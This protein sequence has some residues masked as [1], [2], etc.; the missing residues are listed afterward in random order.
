MNN[1]I[2][3]CSSCGGKNRVPQAKQHLSAKCGKCGTGLDTQGHARPIELGDHDF[4]HFIK[5][6]DLPV[7]VDFFSPTCGPCQALAP[8]IKTL[9]RD[10]LGRLQ[11][12][13]LNTSLHPGTAGHY[14][15][16]GVPT[17]LFFHKG[18]MIDQLVGAPPEHQLRQRI[19]QLLN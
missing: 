16:R 14:Q 1:L 18:E 5:S 12:A 8:I 2:L 11:I 13:T 3:A 15:I 7:M 9:N 6:T 17:L 19:E 4:Q 10:Y